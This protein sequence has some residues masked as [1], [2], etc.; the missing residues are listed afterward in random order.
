MTFRK[1]FLTVPLSLI[2]GLLHAAGG[3]Q[4]APAKTAPYV[5]KDGTIYYAGNDL[6]DELIQQLNEAFIRSHP[7]FHFKGDME[8]SS[9][10]LAGL[11]SGK[12]AFGPIGREAVPQEV[13]GFTARYGYPPKEIL[14]GYDQSPN[15]DIFPPA[16]VP[17]AIWVNT[18]NP[19]PWLS[20]AQVSRILTEGI[21]G[22]DIT[23]WGQLGVGGEWSKRAIHV[24]LPA[25]REAGFVFYEGQRL[26]G[27]PFTSRAEWLAGSREVMSAVAQDPFGIGLVG[28]WPTDSGWDRQAEL[29]SQAKLVP[30][31]AGTEERVSRAALGDLFPMSPGI[32]IYYNQAPGQPLEPWLADYL[33][34]ALSPEFQAIVATR[35]ATDGF[36]PLT[37]FERQKQLAKVN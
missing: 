17:P 11:S 30:L 20:M 33:R 14:L 4:A 10:A 1:L 29:G 21:S 25:A 31:A 8:D 3:A 35:T 18:K 2:A 26:G 23:T 9:L 28:Y 12:S 15:P 24:Y 5:L 6:V 22:G 32:H 27:R 13:E 36:I 16:K 34:L 37:A 19:L 7:G